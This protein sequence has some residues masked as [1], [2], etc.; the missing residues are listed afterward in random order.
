MRPMTT[1]VTNIGSSSRMRTVRRPLKAWSRR[2]ARAMPSTTSM[3]RATD[4]E[5]HRQLQRVPEA[6]VADGPDV[7]VQ[8]DERHAL[9]EG[10]Q[11]PLV[12]AQVEAVG[13]RDADDGQDGAVRRQQERPR[14]VA[15]TADAGEPVGCRAAPPADGALVT[16]C[17]PPL[18]Q[19]SGG[20]HQVL[21]VATL[22]E[23]VLD[24][25]QR[26]RPWPAGASWRRPPRQLRPPAWP[27]RSGRT[28]SAAA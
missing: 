4:H 6:V 10:R 11:L 12:E 16:T 17:G 5:A 2:T 14:P 18:L 23:R 3:T 13:D 8:A 7:V 27:A 20:H 26:H 25:G 22:H 9:L 28:W 1:L 24:A 19:D 21:L 15:W